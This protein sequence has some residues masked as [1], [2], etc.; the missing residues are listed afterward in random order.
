M[1]LRWFQFDLFGD[2]GAV[3]WWR[4]TGNFKTSSMQRLQV[5]LM[6]VPVLRSRYLMGFPYSLM[7]SQFLRARFNFLIIS[8]HLV[9]LW[10]LVEN[11]DKMNE[12]GMQTNVYSWFTVQ[13]T[14]LIFLCWVNT[15]L[16]LAVKNVR[17][18]FSFISNYCLWE[19]MLLKLVFDI[20]N[21]FR[22]CVVTCWSMVGDLRITFPGIVLHIS[23]AAIFL[24]AKSRTWGS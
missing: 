24:I 6:V 7:V 9:I 11:M 2:L 4:R 15:Y 13:R 17:L 14:W 12:K 3:I 21:C 10:M 18:Q 5:L 23:S 19:M 22:N 1:V 16:L 8:W 20:L